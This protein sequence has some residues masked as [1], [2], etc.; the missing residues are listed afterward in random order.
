MQ[1]TDGTQ[2]Q[3]RSHRWSSLLVESQVG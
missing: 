1:E 3:V 2:H